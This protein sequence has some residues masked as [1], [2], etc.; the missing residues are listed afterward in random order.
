MSQCSCGAPPLNLGKENEDKNSKIFQ[1]EEKKEIP[2]P[3]NSIPQLNKN[4]LNQVFKESKIMKNNR[5]NDEKKRFNNKYQ[6]RFKKN[7][8]YL[9]FLIILLCLLFYIIKE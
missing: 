9:F 2:K 1:K 7:N 8:N 5:N 3:S 6:K 4:N